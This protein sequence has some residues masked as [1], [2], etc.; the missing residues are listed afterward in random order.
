MEDFNERNM[1]LHEFLEQELL[2]IP[3][4]DFS[5]C[6]ASRNDFGFPEHDVL[7]F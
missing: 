3:Q 5:K 2:G 6:P 4:F 1:R 7:A